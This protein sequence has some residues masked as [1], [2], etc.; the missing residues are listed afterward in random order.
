MR[1]GPDMTVSDR[2]GA[3]LDASSFRASGGH[4]PGYPVGTAEGFCKNILDKIRTR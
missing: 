4:G 1:W 2:G 3:L